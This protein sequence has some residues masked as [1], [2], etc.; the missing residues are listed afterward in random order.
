V[1]ERR[2]LSRVKKPFYMYLVRD[3]RSGALLRHEL[4]LVLVE[5]LLTARR[6]FGA[7]VRLGQAVSAAE[8]VLAET[9]VAD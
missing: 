8:A 4:V 1:Y 2:N 5:R 9:T 3:L 6:H 7:N